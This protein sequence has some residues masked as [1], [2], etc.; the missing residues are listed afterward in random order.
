MVNTV[1]ARVL[2]GR[3]ESSEMNTRIEYMYTEYRL[4]WKLT[5]Y[6]G[7]L[8]LSNSMRVRVDLQSE[9]TS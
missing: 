8:K 5:T 3:G 1:S 2:H 4:T 6:F 9:T 7:D